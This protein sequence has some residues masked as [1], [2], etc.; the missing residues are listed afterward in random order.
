MTQLTLQTTATQATTI[1]T[2]LE[3]ITQQL[4]ALSQEHHVS[5]TLMLCCLKDYCDR[6]LS[7]PVD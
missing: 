7:C 3:A 4:E 6:R 5:Q 2:A 1:S